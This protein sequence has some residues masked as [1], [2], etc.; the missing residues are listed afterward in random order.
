MNTGHIFIRW[1]GFQVVIINSQLTQKNT[2]RNNVTLCLTCRGRLSQKYCLLSA[3]PPPGHRWRWYRPWPQGWWTSWWAL[4]ASQT[5]QQC[6]CRSSP[7]HMLLLMLSERERRV[8]VNS[9]VQ[10]LLNLHQRMT[11]KGREVSFFFL[12]ET[13]NVTA[14]N[15][16]EC[17]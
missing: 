7:F 11:A 13:G 1:A 10:L 16:A 12:T 3:Q 14:S 17:E 5:W 6:L 2:D 8:P 15:V 4:A 9:A